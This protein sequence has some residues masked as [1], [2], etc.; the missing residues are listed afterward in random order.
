MELSAL[1]IHV[2]E[3]VRD[4]GDLL[5]IA[6][7]EARRRH[8]LRRVRIDVKEVLY[9]ASLDVYVALYQAPAVRGGRFRDA[10]CGNRQTDAQKH[11]VRL[12]V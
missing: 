10:T 5:A 2:N 6:R 3:K 7:A 8:G 12:K 4:L 11:K 9:V 1:V